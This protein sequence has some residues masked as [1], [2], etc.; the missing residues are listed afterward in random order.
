M[1]NR[2]PECAAG[3]CGNC[4]GW[5]FDELD[6]EVPCG[7][8]CQA[9]KLGVSAVTGTIDNLHLERRTTP[10]PPSAQAFAEI[11]GAPDPTKEW[12]LPLHRTEAGYPR[13]STCDGGGCPD[14]TDPA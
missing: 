7:C 11:C 6:R 1:A 5:A 13:C 3:K 12:S 2:C 4:T 9:E 14:C 8:P 10:L